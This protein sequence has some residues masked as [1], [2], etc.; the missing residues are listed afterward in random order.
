MA[1]D[2]CGPSIDRSKKDV[3]VILFVRQKDFNRQGPD[4]RVDIE[5]DVRTVNFIFRA[6]NSYLTCYYT[7]EDRLLLF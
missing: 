2:I 3:I 1:T 5:G 4:E 7:L 6:Y